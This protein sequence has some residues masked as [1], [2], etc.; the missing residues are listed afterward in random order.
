MEAGKTQGP[1]SVPWHAHE[2]EK[3][4]T[5][6]MMLYTR[7]LMASSV[8]SLYKVS[9]I[10]LTE[11]TVLAEWQTCLHNLAN[12]SESSTDG[13][14]STPPNVLV[15]L[16][17]DDLSAPAPS[18]SAASAAQPLTFSLGTIKV[19]L[20]SGKKSSLRRL[21][22]TP[23]LRKRSRWRQSKGSRSL[24][25]VGATGRASHASPQ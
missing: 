11:L 1:K 4:K 25:E 15:E 8:M 10:L 2:P 18:T 23:R 24:T 9:H 7:Y 19:T 21:R 16:A 13:Q 5:D 3:F 14:L 22:I 20:T 17:S 6:V 12:P